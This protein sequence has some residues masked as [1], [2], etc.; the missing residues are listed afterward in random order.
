MT[1]IKVGILGATGAVGQRIIQ[2][3]E[4]H[5]WFEVVSLCA[6]EKSAGKLYKDATTWRISSKI[7]DYAANLKIELCKPKL[8]AE[9]IF[10]GLDS[11]V[12]GD[13]EDQFADN[14]YIVISNS[15]NHRMD[16]DVPLVIPEVNP[17]HLSLIEIQKKRRSSR[18]FIVTNPN[19]TT[20]GLAITLKPLHDTFRVKSVLVTSLQAVSG[21]GYPG[22]PSLDAIDNVIPF[23]KGEEDKV[24]TEP[25]K[26]LGK[27]SGGIIVPADIKISA[28]CN[29]VPVRD[30][31]T[32]CVELSF[33]K[34]PNVDETIQT[35]EKFKGAPQKLSLPSA[36]KKPIIYIAEED[37]PQPILDRDTGHGMSIVVGRVRKS[38]VMDLKLILHVHNTIRGAAG[39]AILNGELLKAKNFLR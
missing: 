5:P 19:C 7:P 9:I 24:E 4:N 28:S 23:I 14:G 27:V 36:P 17:D 10:S 12:A 2:L 37:R 6:S 35:L 25:L 38:N 33:I 15:K 1:K 21:A 32:E 30:G 16:S 11:S 13:I 39:A 26:L 29:R 22:V 20:A 3:L 18:G 8:D 31:H 34:K